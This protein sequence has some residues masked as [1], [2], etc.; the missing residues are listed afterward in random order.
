ML[1]LFFSII[2]PFP[3]L[4]GQL[5]NI[6]PARTESPTDFPFRLENSGGRLLAVKSNRIGLGFNAFYPY[7][8]LSIAPFP[9]PNL[10]AIY[11]RPYR[12]HRYFY[13]ESPFRVLESKPNTESCKLHDKF[14]FYSSFL[15]F[16]LH[17]LR[18]LVRHHLFYFIL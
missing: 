17:K 13:P 16:L 9:F 12:L 4:S 11:R 5:L 6:P 8:R 14:E 10:L 15:S 1:I 3:V 7:L 18:T 2:S